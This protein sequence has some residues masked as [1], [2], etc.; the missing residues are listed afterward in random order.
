MEMIAKFF[1]DYGWVANALGIVVPLGTG[2]FF[3]FKVLMP[4]IRKGDVRSLIPENLQASWTID[5]ARSIV[6]IAIVDDHLQ[7]FPTTELKANG[8]QIQTY[9]QIQLAGIQGLSE[10][11]IVFLDMKGIVKDDPEHGGLKLIA[12][13]RRLNSWQKICA[14]SG[15]TFDPTATE[16]FRQADDYKKKPLTAQECKAVIDT[17]IRELFEPSM[18]IIQ[19]ENTL[20]TLSRAVRVKIIAMIKS[21][22]GG[23]TDITKLIEALTRI[24]IDQNARAP[25][26]CITRVLLREAQ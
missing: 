5:K 26:I 17:F 21:V 23:N 7:D 12:E 15:Q 18:L 14:V 20:G 6:R 2:L 4:W 24:G 9:R 8:F 13:L 22:L 16:F 25:I 3:V 19:S 11:D 10:Y 1:N